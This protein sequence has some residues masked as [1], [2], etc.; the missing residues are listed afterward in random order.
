[1]PERRCDRCVYTRRE[2][3]AGKLAALGVKK[4]A[5]LVRRAPISRSLS[6]RLASNAHAMTIPKIA[7]A[8]SAAVRETALLTPEAMPARSGP[9]EFMTV[10]VSG[11]TVTVIPMP[12][13]TTAGK[14]VNQ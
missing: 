11:A 5:D 6:F 12:S 9:S 7:I 3:G 14:K 8:S 1:V 2:R 4:C 10:V 13:T